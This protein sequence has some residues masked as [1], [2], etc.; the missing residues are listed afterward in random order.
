MYRG[1]LKKRQFGSVNLQ[2]LTMSSALLFYTLI[3]GRWQGNFK[4]FV[5]KKIAEIHL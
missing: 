4:V 5:V 1:C 2:Y 3:E